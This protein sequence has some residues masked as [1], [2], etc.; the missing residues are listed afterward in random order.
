MYD[1][2]LWGVGTQ[3]SYQEEEKRREQREQKENDST[4]DKLGKMAV[5]HATN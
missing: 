4:C 5:I 1:R 3:A 2:C